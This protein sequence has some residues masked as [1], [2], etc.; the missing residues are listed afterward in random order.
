MNF[1]V[2]VLTISADSL[3]EEE[4][5]LYATIGEPEP[6]T[7]QTQVFKSPSRSTSSVRDLDYTG[8][9]SP[10]PDVPAHPE[11]ATEGMQMSFAERLVHLKI[12][13]ENEPVS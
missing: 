9:L 11:H 3:N 5:A 2:K 10:P 4:E 12:L 1:S 7:S 8:P 6:S 13:G